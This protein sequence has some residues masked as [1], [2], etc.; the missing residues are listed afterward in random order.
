MAPPALAEMPAMIQVFT[1]ENMAT[2]KEVGGTPTLRDGYLTEA[3]DLNG[4]GVADYVT[5]I[6]AL[7]CAGAWS[8]F[9]GSAGCPVTVWLSEAQTHA[10]G[11][12]SHAQ[13]WELRG[14]EVVVSLHG[15]LCDPPR[16]GAESCQVALRFDQAPPPPE[17]PAARTSAPAPAGA[18]RIRQAGSSPVIAEGPGVG[19]LEA[20]T[21]LCLRDRPVM[22]AALS[23]ADGAASIT[24]GFAFADRMI[25]V[26]GMAGATTERTY[27][28]DPRTEGLAAA[29]AGRASE[30][31]LHIAGEDQGA[32]SLNGSTRALREALAPCLAF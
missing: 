6:A 22:M 19:R 12:G 2:C 30:V 8:L 20:L 27:I 26:A 3:G 25:E 14:K 16:I 15:Q 32:L 21:A 7:E 17:A 10:V 5:D 23:E 24:F 18:W 31:R 11:W 29:L 13:A 28:L 9:C 4:D 1:Q